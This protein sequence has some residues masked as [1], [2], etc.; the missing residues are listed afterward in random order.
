M[1]Y[2]PN[3]CVDYYLFPI[4]EQMLQTIL[5]DN[6]IHINEILYRVIQVE[7][8][9]SYFWVFCNGKHAIHPAWF[10]YFILIGVKKLSLLSSNHLQDLCILMAM[11]FMK[12]YFPNKKAAI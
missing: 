2:W 10:Y 3:K 8:E 12:N 9:Q 11:L 6:I 5:R 4:A 7:Y 1:I